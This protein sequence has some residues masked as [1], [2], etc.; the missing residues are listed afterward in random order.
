MGVVKN[1]MVRIGADVRGIV[2]G[3]KT[4]YSATRQATSQIKDA[5]AGMK[6]SVKDSFSGSRISIREY[7]ET[8]SRLKA[9]HNTAIQNTERLQEKLTQMQRTYDSL[10]SATDGL[11]LSKPLSK[12]IDEAYAKYIKAGDAVSELR[13]KLR[14]FRASDYSKSDR[15]DKILDMQRRLR[16]LVEDAAYAKQELEQLK[17]V[18]AD[19]GAENINFASSSGMKKLESDIQRTKQELDISKI[20]AEEFAAALA[21]L[22][23]PE[24][25]KAG[26]KAIGAQALAAARNGVARLGDALKRVGKSALDL[27]ITG[28]K[29]LGSGL[30]SLGGAALRGIASLPGKLAGIGRSA[31]SGSGGLERMVRS[32]RNIGIVSLGL[33]VVGG[34]F[35]GLFGELQGIISNYISQNEQLTAT[36]SS[37][38]MQLGQ[39]LA[40]AINIVIAAMQRLMPVIQT[41]A[42][43]INAIFTTLFGKVKT[44]T[45]GIKSS[46][47]AAKSAAQQ[48]ETY[49]FDQITK[50]SD[51]SEDSSGGGAGGGAGFEFGEPPTWM[52]SVLNWIEQMKEA[53]RAGDWEGL[54]RIFGEGINAAVDAINAVDIGS[55]VGT[56]VN[57]LFTVLNSALATIDFFNMGKKVGEFFTSGVNAVNWN[58]VGETIGR[59]FTALPSVTVGFIRNT[60]WAAIGKALT[61]LFNSTLTT[62]GDWVRSVDWFTIGE[63]IE[64]FIGNIKWASIVENLCSGFGAALGGIASIIWALIDDE[65]QQVVDWWHE[66]AYEDGQF[67]IQGLL[68]GILDIISGIGSWIREHIVDPF[69]TNFKNAFGIHSPSTVMAEHG[70]NVIQG[71]LN[72]ILEALANIGSW[73]NEHIVGPFLKWIV[74]LFGISDK[75]STLTGVGRDLIGGLLDGM[76]ESWMQIETFLDTKLGSLVDIFTQGWLRIQQATVTSWQGIGQAI[77]EQMQ[78][79]NQAA[80]LEIENL[81]QRLIQSWSSILQDSGTSLTLMAD[82]MKLRFQSM[83]TDSV[84]TFSDLRAELQKIWTATVSALTASLNMMSAQYSKTH[85]VILAT[86]NSSWQSIHSVMSSR[87]DA[88]ANSVTNRMSQFRSDLQEIWMYMG[89]DASNA[90]TNMVV[91]LSNGFSNLVINLTNS[92][93][94]I[95]AGVANMTSIIINSANKAANA[96][97]GLGT[98]SSSGSYNYAVPSGPAVRLAVGGVVKGPTSAL[99]GE[100][101]KEAVIPLERN[102]GW[103]DTLAQRIVAT[104]GTTRETPVVLKIYLAGKKVSQ[105]VIKDINSITQTTGVCPINV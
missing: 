47:A 1:L 45:A 56:F 46:T 94:A 21:S 61:D 50:V 41:I 51:R 82:T 79:M 101:G 3:M 100:A 75:S 98:Y 104:S 102:T 105:H 18:A 57:N 103:M 97:S 43:V 91:I 78:I 80:T 20:K 83:R 33:R 87:A 34:I 38:K 65:W 36:I 19:I 95:A 84:K 73:I 63:N 27:A 37:M 90:M 9:S 58:T 11:D 52:N 96:I 30:K 25:A 35:R 71:F 4:A 62:V 93:N 44:T 10:K 24:L 12:Q 70:R 23:I 66:N 28:L 49:S 92:M 15:A 67:T 17:Q 53:F 22:H 88:A 81:R 99:I 76:T 8:V 72:G 7:T 74:S 16:A 64:T 68:D 32:I 86:A 48:L 85:A 39:A 26:L 14:E 89:V 5:T 59:F 31:A 40:P 60:D 6:Q 29:K 69:I 2:G 54:G 55:K 13:S 42:S 77:L